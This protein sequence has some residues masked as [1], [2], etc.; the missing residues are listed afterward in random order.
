MFYVYSTVPAPITR[1]CTQ[2]HIYPTTVSIP[3]HL[4]QKDLRFFFFFFFFLINKLLPQ[5]C[6]YAWICSSV[7]SPL[8]EVYVL[9]QC[10]LSKYRGIVLN[11]ENSDECF[12]QYND[13]T[14]YDYLA[15]YKQ[16]IYFLQRLFFQT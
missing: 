4:E 16:P 13:L 14:T 7:S 3:P 6:L 5:P 11:T 15:L 12:M 10:L 9:V 2:R 1:G 8:S